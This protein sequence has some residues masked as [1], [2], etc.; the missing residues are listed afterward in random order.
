MTDLNTAMW[1]DGQA[2]I[3]T[4]ILARRIEG[5]P[6]LYRLVRDVA[7]EANLDE[8][9]SD[10]KAEWPLDGYMYPVPRAKLE[11]ELAA[12]EAKP[13]DD[14]ERR[15]WVERV[16]AALRGDDKAIAVVAQAL[17]RAEAAS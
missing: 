9:R 4:A 8:A 3:E 2:A 1:I 6:P 16:R 12:C 11:A 10:L 5:W 14:P 7:R 15:V 17:L 13:S